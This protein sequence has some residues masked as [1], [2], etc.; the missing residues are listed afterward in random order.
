M[1]GTAA[2]TSAPV[3]H[4]TTSILP[5][6]LATDVTVRGQVCSEPVLLWTSTGS[7]VAH[8]RLAC[9]F[10]ADTDARL[11]LLA[12]PATAIIDVTLRG[13]NA[14]LVAGP[15]DDLNRIRF[16]T[17]TEAEKEGQRALWSTADEFARPLRFGRR[18]VVQGTPRA[19][20][21]LPARRDCP[22]PLGL[23]TEQLP[24][25]VALG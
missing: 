25:G 24:R 14:L 7:P 1:L 4:S 8:F 11:R 22:V 2:L 21:W 15:I 19:G 10:D 23:V 16:G 20:R 18:L 12:D 17:I 6:H 5:R 13:A 9:E 3:V